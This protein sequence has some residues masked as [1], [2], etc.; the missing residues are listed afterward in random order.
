MNGI[1]H[2]RRAWRHAHTPIVQPQGVLPAQ[3]DLA[4]LAPRPL[5][6]FF[7]KEVDCLQSW[8]FRK[9]LL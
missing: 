8:V 2:T 3:W 7:Y 4:L 9:G 1:T 5:A 6:A